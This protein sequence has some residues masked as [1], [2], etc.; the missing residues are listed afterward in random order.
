MTQTPT[1]FPL[2]YIQTYS[3]IHWLLQLD[4][5]DKQTGSFFIIIYICSIYSSSCCKII[6][7]LDIYMI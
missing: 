3:P 6:L 2:T 1:P 4:Q 5:I 7:F